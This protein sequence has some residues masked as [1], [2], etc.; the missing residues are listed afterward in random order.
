MSLKTLLLPITVKVITEHLN[1][2]LQF[3]AGVLRRDSEG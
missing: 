2:F 1:E 3:S